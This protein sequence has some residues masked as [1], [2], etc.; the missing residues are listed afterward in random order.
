MASLG[1]Q[2][3]TSKTQDY[4]LLAGIA[5]VGYIVYQVVQG[6][7]QIPKAATAAA[8]AVKAAYTSTVDATAND[9]YI[10]FG[11]DDAA[12]LGSWIYLTV[13]FPDGRHA[14]PG[15]SVNADGSFVWTG[16]P[17]G[18]QAP[19]TLQLVKDQ[20][21]NWYA[22]DPTDFGVTNPGSWD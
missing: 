18:T 12:A 6:V 3:G 16:Y 7:K 14:V 21:G 4:V 5:F 2:F 15:N 10:L 19:I 17:P 20:Q 11:P 1:S 13:T 8:A 9:L 22:T